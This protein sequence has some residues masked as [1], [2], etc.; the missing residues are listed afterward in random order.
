MA[1]TV[2]EIE[3]ILQETNKLV[4]KHVEMFVTSSNILGDKLYKSILSVLDEMPRDQH[5][6]IWDD[7]SFLLY[8][9]LKKKLAKTSAIYGNSGLYD[10]LLNSFE[11]IDVL[12]AKQQKLVNEIQLSKGW[13][14]RNTKGL[15]RQ[16]K[17]SFNNANYNSQ[18]LKPLE[19]ALYKR[20]YNGESYAKTTEFLKKEL[21]GTSKNGSK[22]SRYAQQTANDTIMQYNGQLNQAIADE[23]KLDG[24]F[25]T[26]SLILDSRSQ[27]VRWVEEKK[28]LLRKSEL[29]KEI[30]WANSQGKGMVPGTTRN[31]FLVNRGGY[32]C[33]HTATP[34]DYTKMKKKLNI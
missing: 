25:Y 4:D 13:I 17:E 20:V 24:I 21:V 2:K 22:L 19:K 6:F 26:N 33:R 1:A 5:G 32:N 27:C 8:S 23:Y 16:T 34:C 14:E 12:V 30:A 7:S 11:E 18:I 31:N 10:I 3:K 28:R 9:S 29:T 15:I